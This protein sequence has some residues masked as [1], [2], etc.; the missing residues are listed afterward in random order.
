MLIGMRM[1]KK[2]PAVLVDYVLCCFLSSRRVVDLGV[3]SKTEGQSTMKG[4][5]VKY[6][7]C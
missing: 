7:I 2:G 6:C 3:T 4:T 1:E 5:G